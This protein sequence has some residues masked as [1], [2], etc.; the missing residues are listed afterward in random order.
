MDAVQQHLLDLYR[1]AQR[2]E[3]APPPPGRDDRRTVR[4]LWDRLRFARRPRAC[5]RTPR[6]ASGG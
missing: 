2:G 5:P 6:T 1:A 4:A 3:P